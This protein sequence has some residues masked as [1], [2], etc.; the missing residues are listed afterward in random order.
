MFASELERMAQWVSDYPQ[1]ETGGSLFGYWTNTGAPVIH[2]VTGPGPQA[3]HNVDSF[4]QDPDYMVDGQYEVFKYFAAQ[5]IGEWHSHH[6]LGLAVPSKGDSNS[7]YSAIEETNWPRFLLG[8]CN[9]KQVGP[10]TD[11]RVGFFLYHADGQVHQ[12]C[13]VNVIRVRSPLDGFRS[14]MPAGEPR[15]K[16]PTPARVR[17]NRIYTP[18]ESQALRTLQRDTWYTKGEGQ[19]RLM[20]EIQG[21]QTL[22]KKLGAKSKTTPQNESVDLALT[23]R[24]GRTVSAKLFNGFPRRS[25]HFFIENR[26]TRP[27]RDWAPD[28]LIAEHLYHIWHAAVTAGT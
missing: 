14:R 1:L 21:L 28:D 23:M 20:M 19:E 17:P 11:I 25:P 12:E 22:E 8:I 6:T 4:Y 5:H 13:E 18:P 3:R 24:D 2:M 7:M 26:R 10:P 15:P 16:N 27:R 9:I